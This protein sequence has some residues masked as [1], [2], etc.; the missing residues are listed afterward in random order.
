FES[1]KTIRSDKKNKLNSPLNRTYI[2]S[3][4]NNII[5]AATPAQYFPQ[6]SQQ[7]KDKH[8]LP[9]NLESVYTKINGELDTDYYLRLLNS[10]YEVLVRDVRLEL[11]ILAG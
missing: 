11:E 3:A 9:L 2:S 4:A 6:V 5:R 1:S 10:R 8:S 7:A